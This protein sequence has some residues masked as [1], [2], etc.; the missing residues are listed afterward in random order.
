MIIDRVFKDDIPVWVCYSCEYMFHIEGFAKNG[1]HLSWGNK[2]AI[3][4]CPAC[5][6]KDCAV[7]DK[8]L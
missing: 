4:Y 7:L 1:F 8:F 5:G 2:E 3:P 6:K